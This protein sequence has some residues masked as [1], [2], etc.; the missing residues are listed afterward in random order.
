[1]KTLEQVLTEKGSAVHTINPRQSVFA[2]LQLMG[3]KQLGALLV[4]DKEQFVGIVSERDYARKVVLLGL[5]S[6][7]TPVSEIMTDMLVLIC[8]DQ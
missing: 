2:A 3:E 5:S 1:M 8:H 7:S 6:L 4:I